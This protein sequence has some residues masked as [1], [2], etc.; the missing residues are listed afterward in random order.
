MHGLSP[1]M[2]WKF[3]VCMQNRI[4]YLARELLAG[5]FGGGTPDLPRRDMTETGC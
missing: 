2:L 4:V 3:S 1:C 5:F